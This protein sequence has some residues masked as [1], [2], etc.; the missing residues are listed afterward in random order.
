MVN[1]Y[2]NFNNTKKAWTILTKNLH[3]ESRH[4]VKM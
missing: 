1:Y 3:D 2:V 4:K